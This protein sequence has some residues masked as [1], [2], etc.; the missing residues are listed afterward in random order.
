M[1]SDW[2]K[3]TTSISEIVEVFL[4]TVVAMDSRAKLIKVR[5]AFSEAVSSAV[6]LF[7]DYSSSMMSVS[8][9]RGE[10]PDAMLL[11]SRPK[12]GRVCCCA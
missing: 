1:L 2:V 8:K 12:K 11:A 3:R 9:V 6:V 4:A 7:L 5:T 10:G